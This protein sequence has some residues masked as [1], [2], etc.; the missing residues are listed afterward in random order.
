MLVGQHLGRATSASCP[1]HPHMLTLSRTYH[2]R[3]ALKRQR[4]RQAEAHGM[5]EMLRTTSPASPHG[6]CDRQHE[7]VGYGHSLLCRPHADPPK[8]GWFP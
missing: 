8:T 4:N 3:R 7:D 6:W 2:H 1:H 5:G